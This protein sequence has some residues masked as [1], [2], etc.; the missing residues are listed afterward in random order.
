VNA[1]ALLL[2]GTLAAATSGQQPD[3]VPVPPQTPASAA[4]PAPDPRRQDIQMM[5]IALTRALQNG[6]RELAQLLRV[7]EPTSAFVTGTGR[8]RGFILEG[9]G[10]FFDVDVPGMKQSVVWSNQVGQLA[11][12][13]ER[14][15]QVLNTLSADDARRGL[16]F[17]RV[18]QIDRLIQAA[19]AGQVLLP[20]VPLA[21]EPARLTAPDRV[22]AASVNES[23]LVA[24]GS[25]AASTP[26]AAL[27]ALQDMQVRDPNELYTEAVKKALIVAML[28]YSKLLKVADQEWL[29]VAA[30]DSDGPPAPNQLDD[31]SRI[32]LSI[33]GVDLSAYQLGRLT[34]EEVLKKVV[35]K[36][37]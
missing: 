24:T 9:Y 34:R 32:L 19:Q 36:E 35:V 16:A 1:T 5:E 21:T 17:A 27:P 25:P 33:R 4:R 37:F 23:V 3:A 31:T 15:L 12:E 20:P 11:Q 13:R 18:R 22:E 8:A 14:T 6:A 7:T 28:D 26:M 30:S 10:I 29:T 2:I